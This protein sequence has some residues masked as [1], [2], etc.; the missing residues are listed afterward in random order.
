MTPRTSVSRA[1][2]RRW[3]KE[4]AHYLYPREQVTAMLTAARGAA[5]LAV[6]LSKPHGPK[7]AFTVKGSL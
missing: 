4:A 3:A 7:H 2:V 6:G 1:L 5:G